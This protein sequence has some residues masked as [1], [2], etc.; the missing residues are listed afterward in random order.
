M[1]SGVVVF[2]DL[3]VGD[4]VVL[5][6]LDDLD[7]GGVV[8]ET[9]GFLLD[10]IVVAGGVGLVAGGVVVV[11][12]ASVAN[13][14]RPVVASALCRASRARARRRRRFRCCDDAFENER[15]SQFPEP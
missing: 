1:R 10:R 7:V 9:S 5:V 8:V 11:V 12:V 2:V 14:Y 6:D 3:N 4:V 15:T 13:A